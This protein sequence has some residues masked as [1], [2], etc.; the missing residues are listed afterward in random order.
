MVNFFLKMETSTS[1][2]RVE[3][4]KGIDN[5]I[6]KLKINFSL[7][8][9]NISFNTLGTIILLDKSNSIGS[10]TYIITRKILPQL[11]SKLNYTSKE[12]IFFIT[13]SD[14][15][16]II[17]T[18][19]EN[20]INLD[21][22]CEGKTNLIPA[23]SDLSKILE[24]GNYTKFRILIFTDGDFNDEELINYKLEN[25]LSLIEHFKLKV[26]LQIFK[27]IS[28]KIQNSK[29]LLS[30]LQISNIGKRDINNIFIT[31]D[32]NIIINN[33]YK[34][35][36]NDCLDTDICLKL[37]D[38][39]NYFM[40][41]PWSNKSN[42]INV[43]LGENI[44]WLNKNFINEYNKN[45]NV[46][47]LIYSKD[48]IEKISF[49]E[50]CN[51]SIDNYRKIIH[52][53]IKFY[54]SRFKT[55][56]ILNTE[57]SLKKLN[58][59]INYFTNFE[60]N[61]FLE[62]ENSKIEKLKNLDK[63]ISKRLIYLKKEIQKRKNSITIQLNM[64]KKG[65]RLSKLNEYQNSKLLR[66]IL[67][68]KS[69]KELV[70]RA[71][72]KG[73]DF[74]EIAKEEILNISNHIEELSDIKD[75]NHT[76]S[77]YST[78]TT[79]EGIRNIAE[80]PKKHKKLFRNITA[81]DTIKI[82]NI[83]GIGINSLIDY[84]PNASLLFIH[85]I[86]IGSFI[87]VSDILMA[88]ECSNGE[89]LHEIGNNNNIINNTIPYFDDERIHL[90]LK[91]YAPK[92]LEYNSSI[93][94]RRVLCDVPS[95]FKYN[96]VIGLYHIYKIM[97]FDK[98]EIVFKIFY[99][100]LQ[101]C[102]N[103]YSDKYLMN[104]IFKQKFNSDHF[105][106][107]IPNNSS[108]SFI[109]PLIVFVRKIKDDLDKKLLSKFLR[110]IVVNSVHQ[111]I[112]KKFKYKSSEIKNILCEFLNINIEENKIKLNELFINDDEPIFKLNYSFNYD[113]L[114][115]FSKFIE[116]LKRIMIFPFIINIALQNDS[117]QKLR[118]LNF[119]NLLKDE[120]I[121]KEIDINYSFKDFIF[122]SFIQGLIF[123][124]NGKRYDIE[125]EK[126][127]IID[128]CYKDKIILNIEDYLINFLKLLYLKDVNYKKS[129]QN[130]FLIEKLTD[131]LLFTN[132]KSEFLFFLKN[133]FSINNFNYS[134][135]NPS[136]N[137]FSQFF[138]S[139]IEKD[140]IPLKKFKI[141]ML[142]VGR[143]IQN[144]VIWNKGNI[145]S[146]NFIIKKVRNFFSEDEWKNIISKK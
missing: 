84:Y 93:G 133:G 118:N 33:I 79:L 67:E 6:G 23:L 5:I 27:I 52:K 14:Y 131:K 49:V 86:Y 102:L 96:I 47:E 120:N 55:L 34:L 39:K 15:S 31:H 141:E 30:L 25:I 132:D 37:I 127:K 91:K 87:S 16:Q 3:I 139:L 74:D 35:F 130:K 146:D 117:I 60:K 28:D 107:Y 77:F 70:K 104:I 94:M 135:K 36:V 56:K 143:D 80:I 21:V 122:L 106:I 20:I 112:K 134:F 66:K 121:E 140:N 126:M 75:T 109:I 129:Q 40:E 17:E 103:E 12:K 61:L 2:K 4:Y 7:N 111:K 32:Y 48:K 142:I 65:E 57:E 64:I 82:L 50:K 9:K 113:K 114:N 90:F 78:C 18:I 42:F 105:L 51:I 26:N 97:L 101:S 99:N 53:K 85:K 123:Y 138:K 69:S 108:K 46:F 72:T 11:F 62:D 8:S 45:E 136:S 83:V 88:S 58:I 137:G 29:G 76:I 89:L 110:A 44:F 95:T 43:F 71:I 92:L 124:D 144:N 100:L 116:K 13:F 38:N 125:K 119:E 145:I 22:D 19:I 115:S 10:S 98:R 73:I 41:D 63:K 128:L 68:T 81:L 59:M 54:F 24:K 1:L